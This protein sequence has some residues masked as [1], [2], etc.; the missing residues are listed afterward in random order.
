MRKKL[1]TVLQFLRD[2]DLCV[3]NTVGYVL[4]ALSGIMYA[5]QL[6]R[7]DNPKLTAV[8]ITAFGVCAVLSNISNRAAPLF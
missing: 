2:G 6:L 5:I 4:F 3:T 7:H 1:K 8:G